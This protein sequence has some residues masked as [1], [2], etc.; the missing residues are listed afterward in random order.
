MITQVVL[1][2]EV[3]QET[4]ILIVV[5]DREI[6]ILRGEL[7]ALKRAL[8]AKRLGGGE[9]DQMRGVKFDLEFCTK[10]RAGLR[11]RLSAERK[12]LEEERRKG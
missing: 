10:R 7:E 4:K 2:E 6:E 5:L 11:I 1:R 12:E 9:T 8:E 3:V